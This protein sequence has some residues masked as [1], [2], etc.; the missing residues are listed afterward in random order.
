[1]TSYNSSEDPPDAASDW[2][3]KQ[4]F[5]PRETR[6]EL[7]PHSTTTEWTQQ[8][9]KVNKPWEEMQ[10]TAQFW[11]LKFEVFVLEYCQVWGRYTYLQQTNLLLQLKNKAFN[12]SLNWS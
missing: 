10:T 8:K 6:V 9:E 5:S 11:S 12:A 7:F 2:A 3:L 1:M 4:A